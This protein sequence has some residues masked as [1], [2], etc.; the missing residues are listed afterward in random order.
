MERLLKGL[1]SLCL[2]TTLSGCIVSRPA[3][4]GRV[5]DAET[6]QPIAGANVV[7]HWHL[8]YYFLEAHEAGEL[9]VLEAVTDADGRFHI[10]KWTR[11]RSP[12]A[13]GSIYS[14]EDPELI[15]FKQGY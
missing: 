1:L 14:S 7:A 2:A 11:V 6:R 15:I 13:R 4:D 12:F 8:K 10:P 5:V 9:Q 3:I